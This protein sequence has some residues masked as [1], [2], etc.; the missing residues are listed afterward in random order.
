MAING[1]GGGG[2]RVA[3]LVTQHENEIAKQ[4]TAATAAGQEPGKTMVAVSPQAHA[5]RVTQ[6]KEED[7]AAKAR[8]TRANITKTQ[9]STTEL[10][11]NCEIN[12]HES[13]KEVYKTT[14][15]VLGKIAARGDFSSRSIGIALRE[16]FE[17]P[18][19]G[20]PSG[21]F[22]HGQKHVGM[23]KEDI[24]GGVYGS[25][26]SA[27]EGYQPPYINSR[28]T[29][30]ANSDAC[31]E[32]IK[33]CKDADVAPTTKENHPEYFSEDNK[34]KNEALPN[35]QNPSLQKSEK[36]DDKWKVTYNAFDAVKPND[37]QLE[38]DKPNGTK[39]KYTWP[40]GFDPKKYKSQ[41][42]RESS[43]YSDNVTIHQ[44][45]PGT[46]LV[47]VLGNGQSTKASCWSKLSDENS[48]FTCAK[49]L[50]TNLAVKPEWNG[51]GNLA[52]FVVPDDA[53]IWVAEGK[54]ASQV[55]SYTTVTKGETEKDGKNSQTF[56]FEG[57]GTQLNILTPDSGKPGFA[58]IESEIFANCTFCFRN[59]GIMD[60][61]GMA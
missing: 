41:L 5:R 31:S 43:S 27:T 17:D 33:K 38:F 57:G 28:A 53:D 54:I 44:L 23:Y 3:G 20:Y 45:K 60:P 18:K 7:P 10:S 35:P 46:V 48:S 30:E 47:R 25:G 21:K 1:L 39:G 51:D 50:Y 36:I 59:D 22:E 2:E 56:V 16:A 34:I 8:M 11:N 12:K 52:I 29:V 15:T 14:A 32:C 49:D 24:D 6:F 61:N 55:G 58:G 9:A 4:T 42:G 37:R 40:E 13:A 26:K 19:L